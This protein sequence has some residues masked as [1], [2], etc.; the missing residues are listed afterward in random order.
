MYFSTD[1]VMI[2]LVNIKSPVGC[3]FLDLLLLVFQMLFVCADS[4][5]CNYHNLN[6]FRVLKRQT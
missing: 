4:Q 5:I 1:N 2:P 3:K 6:D